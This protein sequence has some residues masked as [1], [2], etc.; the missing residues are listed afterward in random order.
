MVVPALR[1]GMHASFPDLAVGRAPKKIGNGFPG[2][3]RCDRSTEG[4]APMT[5]ELNREREPHRSLWMKW[6]LLTTITI[7]A[8]ERRRTP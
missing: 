2:Q 5:P 8:C 7:H 1:Y 6:L 3:L 4:L